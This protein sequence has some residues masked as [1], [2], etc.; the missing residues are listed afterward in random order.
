VIDKAMT[1]R[2]GQTNAAADSDGFLL[3]G[4]FLPFL[5]PS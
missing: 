3:C 4:F 1:P 5:L 2:K